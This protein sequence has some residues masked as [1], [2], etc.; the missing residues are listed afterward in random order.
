[1]DLFF[2]PFIEPQDQD[3]S[4]I[5]VQGIEEHPHNLIY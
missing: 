3:I 2:L 5:Q 1:M 4:S